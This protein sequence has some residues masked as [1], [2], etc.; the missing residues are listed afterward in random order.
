MLTLGHTDGKS[1]HAINL[2]TNLLMGI[3]KEL[4][5]NTPYLHSKVNNY[6][7]TFKERLREEAMDNWYDYVEKNDFSVVTNL[8]KF[9][10]ILKITC[11]NKDCKRSIF[12]FFTK[13][14]IVLRS[15]IGSE[16]ISLKE[17]LEDFFCKYW[18]IVFTY[19]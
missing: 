17:M 1:G 15:P 6:A 19:V 14:A 7:F 3:G 5:K 4:G 8:F 9:Q 2:F 10:L 13:T 18:N 16:N 11:P 12:Q